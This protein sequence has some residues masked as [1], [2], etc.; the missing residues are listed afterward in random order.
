MSVNTWDRAQ[1]HYPILVSIRKLY[2]Y[3]IDLCHKTKYFGSDPDMIAPLLIYIITDAR[4]NVMGAY[5]H[6]VYN[7]VCLESRLSLWAKAQSDLSSMLGILEMEK[8]IILLL[9]TVEK[10]FGLV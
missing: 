10:S 5:G 3:T 7:R 9:Q 6:P 8:I 2:D 1:G 4:S